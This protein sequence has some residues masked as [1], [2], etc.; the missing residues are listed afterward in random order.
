M[1]SG[2]L[3]LTMSVWERF[4]KFKKNFKFD[5]DAKAITSLLDSV[6]FEKWITQ[7]PLFFG[8]E[9]KLKNIMLLFG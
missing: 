3:S 5:T 1:P 9:L 2:T 7:P 4:R 6:E 8:I